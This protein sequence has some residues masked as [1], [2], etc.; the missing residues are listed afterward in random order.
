VLRVAPTAE[1][2]ASLRSCI[3]NINNATTGAP[4]GN[5]WHYRASCTS[6]EPATCV[7]DPRGFFECLGGPGAA[8]NSW[9]KWRESGGKWR[10]DVLPRAHQSGKCDRIRGVSAP[11]SVCMD[12][13]VCARVC[14]CMCASV[15]ERLC[16]CVCARAV[17]VHVSVCLFPSSLCV[18]TPPLPRAVQEVLRVHTRGACRETTLDSVRRSR[19]SR[20]S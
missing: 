6:H 7:A 5:T 9:G 17:S 10:C 11:L 8:D 18:L 20:R 1:H 4:A 13:P 19:R 14:A 12:L 15:C 2:A 3:T 16:V